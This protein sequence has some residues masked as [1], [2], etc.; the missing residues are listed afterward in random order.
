MPR[1][2]GNLRRPLSNKEHKKNLLTVTRLVPCIS[3][4]YVNQECCTL[5]IT[6]ISPKE[7]RSREQM[8]LAATFYT[9]YT[10]GNTAL[11]TKSHVQPPKPIA[12]NGDLAH[13]MFWT[14]TW[15]KPISLCFSLKD[16]G[17]LGEG[18]II[19]YMPLHIENQGV[20]CVGPTM[21]ICMC[22]TMCI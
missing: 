1:S 9:G 4:L 14:S 13:A 18:Y 15:F 10:S 2:G 16:I 5:Y 20:N 12:I 19:I 6:H 11:L 22:V 21:L 7:K 3:C 8:A 17:N